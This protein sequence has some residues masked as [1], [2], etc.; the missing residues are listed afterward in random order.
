MSLVEHPWLGAYEAFALVEVRRLVDER[1]DGGLAVAPAAAPMI[2]QFGHELC[3]IATSKR[4]PQNTRERSDMA[5]ATAR[6]GR[7]YL[8]DAPHVRVV[9]AHA[10]SLVRDDDVHGTCANIGDRRVGWSTM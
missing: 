3:G 2:E 6:T 4:T 7:A 10:E 1:A 5:V 8:D 9:D